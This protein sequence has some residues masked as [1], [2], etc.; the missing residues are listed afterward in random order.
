MATYKYG[1]Y[2]NIG[3]SVARS[4]TQAGTVA[5]YFGTAPVNLVRG[6]AT[7]G[8]VNKP[9]KVIDYTDAQRKIGLSGNWG[10]FTLCEAVEIHFNNPKGNIG[11]VYFVNV[12]NPD[13]HKKA[14]TYEAT[15]ALSFNVETFKASFT[16]KKIKL[17]TLQ[18]VIAGEASDYVKDTDYKVSKDGDTVTIEDITAAHTLA[19]V[20][21]LTAAFE[22]TGKQQA[23]TFTNGRAEFLSDDIILDSF[24]LDGKTEDEDFSIDYNFTKGSVIVSGENLTGTIN[25]SFDE[26][27]ASAVVADDVIGGVT[28]AGEY[29]GLGVLKLLYNEN[30]AVANLIAAPGW[31]KIPEVYKAMLTAS[32]KINGHWEAFVYADIPTED[33]EGG[34]G[35]IATAQAWQKTN[36]YTSE[37]SKVYWPQAQDSTDRVSHLSTWAVAETMRIDE[38]HNGVPFET[39]GNKEIPVIRQYFGK[40]SKNKGFDQQSANELTQVGISTVAFW[41]GAWVLWGD[42]TAAYSFGKDTLDP[43]AIF[44][45]SMRMLFHCVNGFQRRNGVKIDKPFTKRLKEQILDSE[46]EILDGYVEQG[47]LIGDAKILFLESSNDVVDMMNGDFV[48]DLPVTPTPPMKSATINLSYTDAGFEAYFAE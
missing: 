44:D 41:G 48:F 24:E 45:V 11:P 12:L 43:R 16:A 21:G 15:A 33:V 47:A 13:L 10:K 3:D 40:N 36:S 46:Q 38:T 2:G 26:V 17:D 32:Q 34:A 39:C 6:Y 30:N 20:T 8:V 7:A 28:A 18:L 29:S 23:L 27:D 14:Q 4:A 1:A 37:R 42:H 25:A 19:G 35:T 9:V 31:S 5:V 22:C